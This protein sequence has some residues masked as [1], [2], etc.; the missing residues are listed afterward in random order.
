M[1]I[2]ATAYPDAKPSDIIEWA[3]GLKVNGGKTTFDPDFTPQIVE[4]IRAMTDADTRIGTFI[5]P[6]QVGGSTA[7]EVVA[8]YWAAFDSGLFQFNWQN[9]EVAV[10]RWHDRILPVL[11]SCCD[12]KRSEERFEETIC[13][14]RYPNITLRVQGVFMESALDSDTVGRQINEE[15]HLWKPGFLSKARR[16]Q[17][18]VWNAKALDIS[19]AGNVNDQLHQAYEEGTQEVW[20]IN[21]P[22]CGGWHEMQFRFDPNKPELGGLRWDSS[23]CK[24]AEGNGRFNYNKLERTIR[25]EFPCGHSIK[26]FAA[27]RRTLKGRYSAP[28]NEGAHISHRSWTFEGVSCDA[29][30]WLTLIQEW[31][32]AIRSMKVGDLEPMRR[33]RTER[34]CKFWSEDS[35][36]FKGEIVI[37]PTIK[38]N[39]E[40]LPDRIARLW[41]A[42]WQQGY[43][44]LGELEH[45][46]LVI[47]DVLPN[48][49]DQLIFEGRINSEAE[50]IAVLKEHDAI[51]SGAGVVD[52]SKN[53]KHL[54]QFCFQNGFHAIM[55]NQSHR[56]LFRH[57]DGNM[58]FYDEGRPIAN[59]LNIPT[60]Y[61]PRATPNGFIPDGREPLV[62][63]VNKGGMIANHFFIREMKSRVTQ[64]A[65]DEG[66]EAL[67]SEYIECVIP[68]DVSDDFKEQYDSWERVGKDA[69]R[70]TDEVSSGAERFQQK[71]QRDHLLICCAGVDMLKDWAGILGDRLAEL[72]VNKIE[73]KEKQ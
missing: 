39:R 7:G 5:K 12:I 34:E 50:L 10:K 22:K 48:C 4:P 13:V 21:C 44:H 16:R 68:S 40:G 45:F 41:K 38:K 52:C 60:R 29:I 43:K 59:S 9:D 37:S 24:M 69:K 62:I 14:A 49:N 19:N 47:K 1:N 15:I 27:E 30:K 31:H 67:P 28:K 33:F 51:E 63:N 53:T 70:K 65:K 26:D 72:G 35:L 54:L 8:A 71:R 20:E 25:Y 6:V 61:E 11:S 56:G 73:K 58:R 36:P 3:R 42:D 18:R 32:S 55:S 23:G 66:R 46:W 64:A 17:T 57:S 2:F